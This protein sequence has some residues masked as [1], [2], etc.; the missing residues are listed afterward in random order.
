MKHP[1]REEVDETESQRLRTG[2][3][4]ENRNLGVFER[5]LQ[6]LEDPETRSIVATRGDKKDARG[7]LRVLVGF[8]SVF[9]KTD[10]G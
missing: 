5:Q 6:S 9:C 2:R 4:H 8:A 7:L 3:E 1:R 10:L